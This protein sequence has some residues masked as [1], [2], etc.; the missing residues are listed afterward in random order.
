[1]NADLGYQNKVVVFDL[2]DTLYQEL[3]YVLSGYM[4]VDKYLSEKFF[5]SDGCCFD[6]MKDAF[7]IKKNPFD[8]LAE[9][10]KSDHKIDDIDIPELVSIYRYHVP[11]L[12]LK[13]DTEFVLTC[14]QNKGFKMGVITDGRS[15]TQRNKIKALGIEKYFEPANI[16]ISEEIGADKTEATPFAHFVH[17]YPNACGF[18]YVGDNPAKDFLYPNLMGWQTVCLLDNGQNIHSQ[19]DAAS[20]DYDA[21]IKIKDIK[22]LIEII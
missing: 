15:K 5:L 2:D 4:A 14:L 18:V 22:E 19:I 6:I 9:R 1:M 13:E 12:Q 17:R 20:P 21:R 11:V 7:V 8:S 10:L 3:D 16:V